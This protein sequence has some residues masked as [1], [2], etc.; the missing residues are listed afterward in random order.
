MNGRA[1][2]PPPPEPGGRKSPEN[3][4]DEPFPY[5]GESNQKRRKIFCGRAVSPRAGTA[6]GRLG[7]A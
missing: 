2:P 3:R 4:G 6:E 7:A 1:A 5:S